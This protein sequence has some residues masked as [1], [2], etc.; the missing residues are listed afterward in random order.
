MVALIDPLHYRLDRGDVNRHVELVEARTVDREAGVPKHAEHHT[1]RRQHRRI[2]AAHPALRPD[3]RQLLEHPR[4]D[5]APLLVIR[6]RQ[7]DLG[8]TRLAQ[9]LVAARRDH[10]PGM[11]GDQGNAVDAARLHG[12]SRDDVRASHPV[13]AE[14]PA[15][16][17]EL[18]I[19]RPY[20]LIIRRAWRLQPQRRAIAKQNVANEPDGFAGR[21]THT[22]PTDAARD[23]LARGR[24]I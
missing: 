16:R 11:T 24:T 1:V 7:R 2:E 8:H 3:R 10:T 22:R 21:I 14:V 5:P 18:F 4:S 19:E 12:G 20:V 9:P 13:E 17:R 6:H 15:L 23:R